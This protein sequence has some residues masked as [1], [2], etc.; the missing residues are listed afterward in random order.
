MCARLGDTGPCPCFWTVAES[1]PPLCWKET[2]HLA[3]NWGRG[4]HPGLLWAEGADLELAC[5]W[6]L[7]DFPGLHRPRSS[8]GF[9]LTSQISTHNCPGFR[10]QANI[11]P[12][13]RGHGRGSCYCQGERVPGQRD[14]EAVT[15][16]WRPSIAG[17]PRRPVTTLSEAKALQ[18]HRL[19]ALLFTAGR[20]C[21]AQGVEFRLI[22][23]QNQ[24]EVA[25]ISSKSGSSQ[26]L[27]HLLLLTS[28]E[29]EAGRCL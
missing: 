15:P 6:I 29:K 18:K 2:V 1:L 7:G 12:P 8:L 28:G 24:A 13:G 26:L 22:P 3:E 21:S 4:S 20:R 23:P 11:P 9:I 19:R 14:T 27:S 10:P 17:A 5:F 25:P 16:T